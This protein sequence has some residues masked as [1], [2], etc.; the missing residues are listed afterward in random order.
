MQRHWTSR[1]ISTVAA[2]LCLAVLAPACCGPT[3]REPIP[4]PVGPDTSVAYEHWVV[5]TH[6]VSGQEYRIPQMLA[7][8]LRPS[9]WAIIP[10]GYRTTIQED[11]ED[12]IREQAWI[13]AAQEARHAAREAAE[14]PDGQ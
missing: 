12:L 3:I 9:V 4:V 8:A 6:P 11:M 14:V 5:W 10:E 1:N 7:M 2:L 13:R